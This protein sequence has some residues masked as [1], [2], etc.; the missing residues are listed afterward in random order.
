MSK[1]GI[2][3]IGM[4]LAKEFL[5]KRRTRHLSSTLIRLGSHVTSMGKAYRSK[6][7]KKRIWLNVIKIPFGT[8]WQTNMSD[9]I[10]LNSYLFHFKIGELL[11]G[12]APSN[13][14]RLLDSEAM[15]QWSTAD[16]ESLTLPLSPS[17]DAR[18]HLLL[19]AQDNL[20]CVSLSNYW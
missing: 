18:W 1:T 9:E 16:S 13:E 7:L 8:Q 11:I 6:I 14:T 19:E 12:V 5:L 2:D 4:L 3:K 15:S 17:H 10:V 20:S